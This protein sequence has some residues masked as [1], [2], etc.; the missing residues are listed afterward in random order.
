MAPTLTDVAKSANVALSTAS[1]AFS[2][3]DRLGP[4]TLRKVLTVAQELGY[5]P[6]VAR[7]A[8]APTGAETAT[9]AVVVPDIANPV[10][11]SFVKAAQGEG[12][13]RRQT[14]VLADTDLDPGREREVIAH[15]TGQVDG[16][17]VC[18]PRLDADEVLDLCGRTPVVLVNRETAGADCV[19][20]DAAHGLRQAVE[21]L[22]A[23][24]HRRI[25]YVQG[26]QRSWSNSHRVALIRAE[27][28][29]AG[30]ELELL[31]WQAETAAGGKAA[32][33]SVMASGASAV[34]AHNDLMALGVIAGARALGLS[35]PERLSVV[36]VDDI[37]FAD[38]AQ[39]SLTS[40]AVPMARAGALGHE[41]LGQI[42]GG[43]RQTPRTL[44]LPTQ[45]IV[46]G[47][48]GPAHSLPERA[49]VAA[50]KDTP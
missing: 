40:I 17:I 50:G 35:V 15:L 44:R 4:R 47:S 42:L 24:G 2:N 19:I 37:P 6:P 16:L 1:R 28:E 45:L 20:A 29:R 46:R 38:V 32:A 30:L 33:A 18:S 13:R 10:F 8:E 43:E 11:G 14:V 34:I 39:P 7:A 48:T 41:L 31:G 27:T 25:A 9:V 36:G 3:P 26:M 23:L 21:Y 22:A 5:E 12:W 49:A